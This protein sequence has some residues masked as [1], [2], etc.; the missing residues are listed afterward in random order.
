MAFP[1]IF[2]QSASLLVTTHTSSTQQKL[3]AGC[4]SGLKEYNACTSSSSAANPMV[5]TSKNIAR[6]VTM[7]VFMMYSFFDD[8][9]HMPGSCLSCSITTVAATCSQRVFGWFMACRLIIAHD[10]NPR[11]PDGWLNIPEY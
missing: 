4:L 9:E 10:R 11:F 7:T 3:P 8:A 2:V 1:L 5:G 6:I